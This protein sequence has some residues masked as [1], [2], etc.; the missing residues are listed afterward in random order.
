MHK[1]KKILKIKKR[2]DR[3]SDLFNLVP[4]L[5][6]YLIRLF[7]MLMKGSWMHYFFGI[8]ENI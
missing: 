7:I 2:Q 5:Q 3:I 6:Y 1:L 8:A 4:F